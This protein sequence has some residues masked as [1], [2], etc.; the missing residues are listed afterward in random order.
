MTKKEIELLDAKIAYLTG[1]ISDEV[2]SSTMDLINQLI[3]CEI[4]LE[5][6]SN[7]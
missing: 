6:E 1:A 7:K 4:E 5:A 3:A 2:G